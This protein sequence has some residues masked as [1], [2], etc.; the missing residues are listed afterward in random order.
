MGYIGSKFTWWNRSEGQRAIRERLDRSLMSPLLR[1]E[2]PNASLIHL[3]D[4][5][6]NHRLILLV[7]DSE[8]THRKRRFRF[9]ERWCANSVVNSIV[10]E[11]SNVTNSRRQMEDIYKELAVKKNA[12]HPN[13]KAE[14]EELE[15]QL[16]SLVEQE[17]RY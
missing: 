10:D 4:L 3:E 5:R 11:K 17:E 14:I 13:S 16:S 12:I 7:S 9:Q 8:I 2:F 15:D 1:M 6:S